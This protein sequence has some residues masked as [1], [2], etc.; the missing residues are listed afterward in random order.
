MIKL[1]EKIKKDSNIIDDIK[2]INIDNI[3]LSKTTHI[4]ELEYEYRDRINGNTYSRSKIT[5]YFENNKYIKILTNYQLKCTQHQFLNKV[6]IELNLNNKNKL[7]W[8][9][10]D[11]NKLV[12]F[13][14]NS[15]L[16]KSELKKLSI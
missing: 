7:L 5:L 3:E 1:I 4:H 16:K 13:Y 15:F 12:I 10:R 2:Y 6:L 8:K 11:N 9:Y 14:D